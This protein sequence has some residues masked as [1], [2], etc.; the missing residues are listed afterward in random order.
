MQVTQL[1]ELTTNAVIGG[2]VAHAATISDSVEFIGILSAGIYSNPTLAMV[3]EVICNAWDAHI[4]AGKTDMP[5]KIELTDEAFIVT[6]VGNGLSKATIG[7]IYTTYGGST[8]KKDKRQTGGFGLGAKSPWS[9]T[10]FFTVS[11]CHADDGE[12][13]IYT[14]IKSDPEVGGRPS[15]KEMASYPCD[16]TGIIVNVPI[17]YQ[18]KRELDGYIKQVVYWG[19]IP[20]TLNER[21]LPRAQFEKAEAKFCMT[22][23]NLSHRQDFDDPIIVKVGNVV[24]PLTRRPAYANSYDAL[25]SALYNDAVF[26]LLADAGAVAITPSR[27]SLNYTDETDTYLAQL[28]DRTVKTISR[29]PSLRSLKSIFKKGEA[30]TDTTLHRLARDMSYNWQPRTSDDFIFEVSTMRLALASHFGRL[31]KKTIGALLR[32]HVKGLGRHAYKY[33]TMSLDHRLLARFMNKLDL[34]GDLRV[35]YMDRKLTIRNAGDA[36]KIIYVYPTISDLRESIGY[37][38]KTLAISAQAI[39]AEKFQEFKEGAEKL[40]YTVDVIERRKS[41]TER[42]RTINYNTV[43][44]KTGY[45][46]ALE[47]LTVGP[48]DYKR[49]LF[50]PKYFVETITKEGRIVTP[51]WLEM[52]RFMAPEMLA[53]TAIVT[54]F[55]AADA[56]SKKGAK[57]AYQAAPEIFRK[58]V[59]KDKALAYMINSYGFKMGPY[60]DTVHLTSAMSTVMNRNV[61]LL[62]SLF[63]TKIAREKL[64]PYYGFFRTI[65]R[66][67]YTS[68]EAKLLRRSIFKLKTG[69]DPDLDFLNLLSSGSLHRLR[70]DQLMELIKTTRT[71]SNR[72]KADTNE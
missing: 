37:H 63:P 70:D 36:I 2:G 6:D 67:Y 30:P 72:F 18:N 53:E 39:P 68:Y 45:V 29:P 25:S 26:V 47:L 10:D 15:L 48:D 5:V 59:K 50:E 24:Y 55:A 7:P 13:T 11:S 21:E 23:H 43:T 34:L 66:S 19:D 14:A 20:A 35:Q 22:R 57:A 42:K 40:G 62:R 60:Y 54:S 46:S 9:F 51:E 33:D 52:I 16:D 56:L 3:R 58:R 49:Q 31:S 65:A 8:K 1:G 27:E 17:T 64:E 32:H 4:A 61:D 44:K 69:T 28:L 38:S 12:R 41:L 71:L